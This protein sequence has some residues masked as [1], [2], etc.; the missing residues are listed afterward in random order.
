M[1]NV[2]PFDSITRTI[3]S[4]FADVKNN[5]TW[6]GGVIEDSSMSGKTPSQRYD[7]STSAIAKAIGQ[8]INYSPKKIDYLLDQYGGIFADVL[9]PATSKSGRVN[10]FSSSFTVNTAEKSKIYSQFN[11][12]YQELTYQKNDGDEDAT[13]KLKYLN[14]YKTAVRDVWKQ[15]DEINNSDLSSGEKEKQRTALRAIINQI[16]KS[17]MQDYEYFESALEA[18]KPIGNSYSVSEVTNSNYSSLGL[19]EESVGKYAL[20]FNDKSVYT[21]DTQAQAE[22]AKENQAKSLVYAEATRLTSGAEEALKAYN[23]TVYE[24]A[25]TLNSFGIDYDLYYDYYFKARYYSGE[26]K[27]Q[28]CVKLLHSLGVYCGMESV[29]LYVSGYK[30]EAQNVKD[31]VNSLNISSAEKKK[32][33]KNLGID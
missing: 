4:P 30:S 16:Y 5:V 17:G 28:N 23:K 14:K 9:I 25:K 29:M 21:Y 31:Y 12:L 13:Y 33:L 6:Y 32:M 24:K 19:S 10:V 18:A 22:T 1:K 27:R 7:D 2:T 8:A 26:T 20:T 11:D 15:I 3:F